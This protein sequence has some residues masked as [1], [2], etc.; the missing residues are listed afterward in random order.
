MLGASSI[1]SYEKSIFTFPGQNQNSLAHTKVAQT[2]CI[3]CIKDQ[4]F[5]RFE[6]QRPNIISAHNDQCFYE[7]NKHMND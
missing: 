3:D 6:N 7:I 2:I 1:L 4:G 5:A